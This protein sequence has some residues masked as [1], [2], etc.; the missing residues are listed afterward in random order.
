MVYEKTDFCQMCFIHGGELFPQHGLYVC[1]GCLE[2]MKEA[3]E[4]LIPKEP[5][6][7]S[8]QF[9]E[10]IDNLR[11]EK[12]KRLTG[13]FLKFSKKEICLFGIRIWRRKK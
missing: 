1:R 2:K 11:K 13:Y 7:P 3:T 5:Q 6:K 9:K 8:D 10:V 4:K 12:E